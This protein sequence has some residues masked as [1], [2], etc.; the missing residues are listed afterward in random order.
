MP[1]IA[2]VANSTDEA[3]VFFSC[4]RLLAKPIR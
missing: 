1:G 2:G 3:D 4:L